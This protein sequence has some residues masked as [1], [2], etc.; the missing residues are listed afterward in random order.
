MTT[1]YVE[2]YESSDWNTTNNVSRFAKRVDAEK[3]LLH[4]C[5][6]YEDL[7]ASIVASVIVDGLRDWQ[8]IPRT[9]EYPYH[10]RPE[11]VFNALL[12]YVRSVD[13]SEL[14]DK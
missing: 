9:S 8:E 11:G 14:E 1:F 12:D 3:A 7:D 4:A 10:F 2:I 6:S 5:Q 13:R